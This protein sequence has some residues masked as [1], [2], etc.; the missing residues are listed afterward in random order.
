MTKIITYD[1]LYAD[2]MQYK[3]R[4]KLKLRAPSASTQILLTKSNI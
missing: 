1:Y 3:A 4:Y 2:H